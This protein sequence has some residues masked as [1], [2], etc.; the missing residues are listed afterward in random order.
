MNRFLTYR[1]KLEKRRH[2]RF[3]FIADTAT[4]D[5]DA[6]SLFGRQAATQRTNHFASRNSSAPPLTTTVQYDAD[7]HGTR[8]AAASASAA[9]G[10]GSPSS[11]SICLI[12]CWI[13][14]LVAAP[15]PTMACLISRG[16]YSKDRQIELERRTNSRRPGMAQFQGT[17]GVLVH[18]DTFNGDDVGPIFCDDLTDG[19]KYHLQALRKLTVNAVDRT[20]GD[21]AGPITLAVQHTKAG[22]TRT[23]I[24]SEYS[25]ALSQKSPQSSANTSSG[26]SA[27]L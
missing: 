22:Q 4:F 9:S 5:N 6:G 10:D 8:A 21:V 15:V 12:M 23:G 26:I 18:E 16:A 2:G 1:R 17:A 27:L 3:D 19:A 20:A 11:C 24:N 7:W 25:L 13:C 14:S